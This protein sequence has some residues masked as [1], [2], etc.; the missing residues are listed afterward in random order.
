M[1]RLGAICPD[2]LRILIMPE[3]EVLLSRIA[4]RIPE[5]I[6]GGAIKEGE[7]IIKNKLDATRAIGAM[8]ICDMLTGK[9]SESEAIENWTVKTNQ[10]A[11]LQRTWFNG[12]YDANIKISRI[13]NEEDLEHVV[14][15]LKQ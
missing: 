9:I 7:D 10:Y 4:S 1:P 14:K 13:P 15:V 3:R 6:H 5:M 12:Q 2:A 11:K 8:Q